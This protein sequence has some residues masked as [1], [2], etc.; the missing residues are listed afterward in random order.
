[1]PM[2]MDG[3][4]GWAFL[5]AGML[6]MVGP[7]WIVWPYLSVQSSRDNPRLAAFDPLELARER[8]AQGLMAKE[9][10]EDVVQ[11]L[12]HTEGLDP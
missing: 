10:F 2:M 4:G 9:E 8:Y 3:A 6:V 12:L 7:G 5:P 11:Q 1:M